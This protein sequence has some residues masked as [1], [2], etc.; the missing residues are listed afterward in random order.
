MICVACF[1]VFP[2]RY[3]YVRPETHGVSG[4]LFNV[5]LGFDKPFNEAPSL[6][7]SLAVILWSRFEKHLQGVWRIA[8]G[9]WLL[10][11]SLSTMTTYQH[12]F[13]D[14]PTGAL[15][16]WLAIS[17]VPERRLDR[18]GQRFRLASFYLSGA[19][20]TAAV[21]SKL[22]GWGWM[23]LWPAIAVLVVAVIY[24][25]D[26]PV[27]FRQ[28]VVRMIVAPYTVCAWINSRWWT[29]GENEAEQIA[30]GVWLGRA[31]LG[32][33]GGSIVNVAAELEV[34]ACTNVPMLDLVQPTRSQVEEAVMA[35]ERF[36]LRR[37]TLVCCALG[38]ERSASVV[39]AWLVSTGRAESF[40]EAAA[41]IRDRRPRVVLGGVLGAREI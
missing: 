34:H 16:G 27:V 41:M 1:L 22:Q 24:I 21:A 17:L 18:R 28:P 39:A 9:A 19:C 40:E 13:I 36:A 10:L 37:P 29:R 32:W 35:V 7:V 2:L 15:V 23:L 6:H 30:D 8:M 20:L 38:Y 4:W 12:Q 25:A 3:E 14:L 5:L 11:V 33:A 31:P 26:R